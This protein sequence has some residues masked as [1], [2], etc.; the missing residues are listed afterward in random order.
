LDFFGESERLQ[1]GFPDTELSGGLG[2]LL[3][4]DIG[5]S[6]EFEARIIFEGLGVCLPR[7]PAP[8]TKTL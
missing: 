8:M 3:R 7:L 1:R 2:Q 4:A 5:K 6:G